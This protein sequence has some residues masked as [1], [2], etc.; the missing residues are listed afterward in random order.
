METAHLVRY[1]RRLEGL[2]S[3]F[4]RRLFGFARWICGLMSLRGKK[5]TSQHVRAM[6][7]ILKRRAVIRSTMRCSLRA[8]DTSSSFCLS[9]EP[10][11]A[12]YHS[13]TIEGTIATMT[14]RADKGPNSG[15]G[16]IQYDAPPHCAYEL[17]S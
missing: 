17:H 12:G 4:L 2:T 5:R 11:R 15:H 16:R 8:S 3:F 9:G 10:F 13:R 7:D 14:Q 6:S 1:L